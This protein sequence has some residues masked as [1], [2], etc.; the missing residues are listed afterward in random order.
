VEINPRSP[1]RLFWLLQTGGWLLVMPI[2][3]GIATLIFHDTGTILLFAVARQVFGFGLSLGLWQLYLRWPAASFNLARHAWQIVLACLLAATADALLTGAG[4]R[5]FDLPPMPMLVERGTLFSRFAIYIAWSA[6]YFVLRQEFETRSTELRLARAEAANREAELQLLRAQVNPHFLFNA[7][8]TIIAEAETNPAAVV[9]TTHA[10]ADYLRYSL[11]HGAHQAP[12]GAELAAM[13]SYLHVERANCG[14]DRLDWKIEASDAARLAIV[15]TALV[16]PLI[17]NALK[18]G[19]RN[20]PPPL[21]LRVN[22]RV[23]AGEVIITVENSGVWLSRA[24]G[25]KAR[26][27]TGIGLANLRRRLELLCGPAAR[28][29]TAVP[30]GLVRVEVRLPFVPPAA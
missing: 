3:A 16:Q 25:E 5:L 20:S 10:V 6:I 9:T 24:P 15:P 19:P 8:T 23:E 7:L 28:L 21:Q 12:L 22:A 14:G 27:S 26:D 1:R 4:Q 18:Y 2:S 29:D 11:S 30:A 13:S 17:E